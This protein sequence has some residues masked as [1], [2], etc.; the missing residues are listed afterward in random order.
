MAGRRVRPRSVVGKASVWHVAIVRATRS[1]FAGRPTG[2]K[3]GSFLGVQGSRIHWSP[4]L[5]EPSSP[6]ETRNT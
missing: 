4:A 3:N 6:V 1:E 2:G 5:A